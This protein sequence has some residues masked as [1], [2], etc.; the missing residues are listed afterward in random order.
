MVTRIIIAASNASTFLE[1]LGVSFASCF[2]LLSLE[3]LQL[4]Q[5][6][7]TLFEFVSSL[8]SDLIR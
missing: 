4:R 6:H 5:R 3:L 1:G 7:S 2:E 8:L